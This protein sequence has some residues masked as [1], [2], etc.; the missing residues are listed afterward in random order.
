MTPLALFFAITL[1]IESYY[2]YI[3]VSHKTRNIMKLLTKEIL[4]NFKRQGD[5]SK[6]EAEQVKVIVKFFNPVG[7]G[8]WYATEYN[9][10]EKMFFGYV[11]LFG[12][13]NDELGYFSL[14]ELESIKGQ[15]GLG[16]ER[17]MYFRKHTLKEVMSMSRK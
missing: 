15:F 8:T 4:N 2:Y 10:D 12:D 1:D 16:I 17:D 14:E 11:S 7:I 13:H 6:M 9:E 5:T 3:R